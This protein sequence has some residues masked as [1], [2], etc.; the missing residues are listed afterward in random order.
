MN[1]AD[2]ITWS[3]DFGMFHARRSVGELKTVVD[4]APQEFVVLMRNDDLFYVYRRAELADGPRG[5]R[6]E[7]FGGSSHGHARGDRSQ[8]I[9]PASPPPPPRDT[10]AVAPSIRRYVSLGGGGMP[11]AVGE[12]AVAAA[13]AASRFPAEEQAGVHP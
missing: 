10:E 7:C 2:P 8:P 11:V 4:Q 12:L 13:A 3:R 5:K 9:D 6:S 1:A